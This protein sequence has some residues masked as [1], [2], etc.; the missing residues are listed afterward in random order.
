[1]YDYV[2]MCTLTSRLNSCTIHS[3]SP[4]P[5]LS[6]IAQ[7]LQRQGLSWSPTSFRGRIIHTVVCNNECKQVKP[8]TSLD[9]KSISA[10]Y[11]ATGK[12]Q[13]CRLFCTLE[14]WYYYTQTSTTSPCMSEQLTALSKQLTATT[15]SGGTATHFVAQLKYVLYNIR[16]DPTMKA[17]VQP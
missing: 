11:I 3:E 1:M 15:M 14:F 12:V 2:F 4:E 10:C 16:I 6:H 7:S 5:W 17:R 9:K 13:H 8:Q